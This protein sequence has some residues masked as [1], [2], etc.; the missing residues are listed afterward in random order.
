MSNWNGDD[1][2]P[3]FTRRFRNVDVRLTE[4]REDRI[5]D[6]ATLTGWIQK[7][8]IPAISSLGLP[9]DELLL[10][11]V[12]GELAGKSVK[13]RH[14]LAFIRASNGELPAAAGEKNSGRDWKEVL[15]KTK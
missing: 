14:H 1:L 4:T 10:D 13:W 11:R 9:D 2:E 8:Y 3:F 12:L 7:T 6:K 5:L 15:N